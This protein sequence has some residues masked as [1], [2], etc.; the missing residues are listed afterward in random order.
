MKYIMLPSIRYKA[1]ILNAFKRSKITALLGPRKCGK[2][3][4]AREISQQMNSHYLD[5]ES[6]AD[7]AKLQNPELYLANYPG[8]IIIDEIQQMPELF[9]VLRVL[10]DQSG[11]T[12]SH[13]LNQLWVRGGYP[14]SYLAKTEED[15]LAWREG[16]M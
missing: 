9:P 8:M 10:S 2:T 11:D 4:L 5:L 7:R 13:K 16:F 1:Q 12:G 3:T 6:P 14:L 15:S